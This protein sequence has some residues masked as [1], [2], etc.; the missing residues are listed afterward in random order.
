MF[1]PAPEVKKEAI[2]EDKRPQELF[3]LLI[4]YLC[5]TAIR[6][7]R[8]ILACVFLEW[9]ESASAEAHKLTFQ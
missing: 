3:I 2:V 6:C 1:L 7:Y 8:Y 9:S 4:E 5:A